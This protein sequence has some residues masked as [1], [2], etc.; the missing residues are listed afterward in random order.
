MVV[1]A[2]F[3]GPKKT[4]NVILTIIFTGIIV[5]LWYYIFKS[6]A[7]DP[8]DPTVKFERDFKS[9]VRNGF[10]EDIYEYHCN[11]CS[12]HVLD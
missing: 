4:L 10:N 6:T 7:E 12:T 2:N 11:I 5:A 3:E 1:S 8:S 9:G